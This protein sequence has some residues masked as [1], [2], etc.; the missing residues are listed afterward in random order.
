[1]GDGQDTSTDLSPQFKLMVEFWTEVDN[2]RIIK[3]NKMRNLEQK[4]NF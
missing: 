2:G 1:M 3:T 4:E